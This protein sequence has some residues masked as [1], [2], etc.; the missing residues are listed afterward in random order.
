[1]LQTGLLRDAG[2]ESSAPCGR[3]LGRRHDVAAAPDSAPQVIAT[4]EEKS[5]GWSLESAQALCHSSRFQSAESNKKRALK[6][7]S[8]A[9]RPSRPVSM[10]ADASG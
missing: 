8:A 9:G 2:R 3:E 1:V 10:R 6:R 5:R 4:I 7:F